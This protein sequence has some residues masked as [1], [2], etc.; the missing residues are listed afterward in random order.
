[1]R[2]CHARPPATQHVSI[3]GGRGGPHQMCGRVAFLLGPSIRQLVVLRVSPIAPLGSLSVAER[4]RGPRWRRGTVSRPRP[5]VAMVA[6]FSHVPVIV[7]QKLRETLQKKPATPLPVLGRPCATTDC[8]RAFNA[9]PCSP[10]SSTFRE[11]WLRHRVWPTDSRHL[12]DINL[13]RL[14]MEGERAEVQV[15]VRVQ[16]HEG[17][18]PSRLQDHTSLTHETPTPETVA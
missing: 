9:S 15:A 5:G 8:L 3:L 4:S 7:P 10:G 14:S 17:E 2:V 13:E 1:M 18:C 6:S 11:P 12:P 16:L